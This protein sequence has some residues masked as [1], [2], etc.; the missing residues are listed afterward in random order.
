VRKQKRAQENEE[1]SLLSVADD[2]DPQLLR[3]ERQ[4]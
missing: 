2:C 3:C 4:V 1:G